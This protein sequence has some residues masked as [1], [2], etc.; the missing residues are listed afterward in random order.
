M[1]SYVCSGIFLRVPLKNTNM[2]ATD[3]TVITIT[4]TVKAPVA[5]VWE[6]WTN[7]VH[8]M[9]WNQA[10]PDWH[11]PSSENDVRPGGKF[12]AR[13][14]AKDGSFG[15]EFGGVYDAVKVHELL[16][17]T[18]GDG[19]TI[20][21]HFTDKGNETYIEESFDAETTNPIE[22]QRAGWQSI[23]DSFTRYTE[24]N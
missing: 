19:R 20:T 17:S 1:S 4:S 8:I 5:K 21:V 2:A 3:K 15:F 22:M 7:P 18:I 13:M 24:T 12:S 11:C 6:Y 9:K 14:E 10:S 16:A 23:L